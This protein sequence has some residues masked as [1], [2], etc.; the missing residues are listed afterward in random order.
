MI[1]VYIFLSIIG[2]IGLGVL[3]I[4]CVGLMER[5]FD[6]RST[7]EGVLLYLGPVSLLVVLISA[8]IIFVAE[9]SAS[10]AEKIKSYGK[11]DGG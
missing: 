11:S 10:I 5:Y 4:Y 7:G 3:S 9:K 2:W 1:F 8:F 6:F